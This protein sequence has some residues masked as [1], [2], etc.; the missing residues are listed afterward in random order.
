[1]T[2]RILFLFLWGVFHSPL[3]A[4]T[5]GPSVNIHPHNWKHDAIVK[6]L[7]TGKVVSKRPMKEYLKSLGKK[8]E[9]DGQV[10]LVELDNGLKAVFKAQPADDLGDAYAEVAAYRASVVLG[11][12]DIPPTIMFAMD[13]MQGSLQLFVDT[14]LDH[15]DSKVYE[16]ALQEASPDDVANLKLFYFIFGQWDSGKHNLLT[17]KEGKKT[18]LIAIDNSGM[19]NHQY[20]QYGDLPFVRV[21]YSDHLKSQDWDAPFPFDKAQVIENPTSEKLRKIFGDQLPESFYKSFKSYAQKPYRYV[22]YRNSLWR[23]FHAQDP[24]FVKSF[25]SYMPPE[26]RRKLERLS[27]AQLRKIFAEAKNADFLT[28]AYLN[29]I[30]ERRDQVL[31]FFDQQKCSTHGK[32]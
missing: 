7:K 3:G 31:H 14:P 15:L 27:M 2:I 17:F 21:L 5:E 1:M 10:F 12:P 6:L 13:G 16:A 4:A 22:V 25:T 19:R 28:P 29:A 11:F 18:Y 20:V 26:T 8:S 32:S 30:L 24:D 9:F 23:Q